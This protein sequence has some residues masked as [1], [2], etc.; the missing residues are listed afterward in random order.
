MLIL[1]NNYFNYLGILKIGV[2]D[3]QVVSY[4]SSFRMA[5]CIYLVCYIILYVDETGINK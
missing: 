5:I 4:N 2:L 1:Y 3:V